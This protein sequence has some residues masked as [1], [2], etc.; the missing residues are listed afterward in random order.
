M[1]VLKRDILLDP[2]HSYIGDYGDAERFAEDFLK[3]DIPDLKYFSLD[4]YLPRN[5]EMIESWSFAASTMGGQ[6]MNITIDRKIR[7]ETSFWKLTYSESSGLNGKEPMQM[8]EVEDT[9]WVSDYAQ[10]KIKA[11]DVSSVWSA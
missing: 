1:E 3:H 7:N 11:K 2:L 10:F 5:G 6:H 4:E 8:M 9:G